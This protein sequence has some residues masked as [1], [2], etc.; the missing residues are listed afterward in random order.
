MAS[1]AGMFA[2][3]EDDDAYKAYR[4]CRHLR[5]VLSREPLIA[6]VRRF[7]ARGPLG[8]CVCENKNKD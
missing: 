7:L 1:F 5:L 8:V 3:P 6:K 4:R 2:K